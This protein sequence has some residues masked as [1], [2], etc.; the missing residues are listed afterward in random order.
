MPNGRMSILTGLAEPRVSHFEICHELKISSEPFD[1]SLQKSVGIINI[2]SRRYT[3][4][5]KTAP[6]SVQEIKKL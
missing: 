3:G 2:M 5:L 1:I 6:P 4:S